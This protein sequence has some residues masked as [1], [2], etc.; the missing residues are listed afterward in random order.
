MVQNDNSGFGPLMVEIL[1]NPRL[2]KV[3]ALSVWDDYAPVRLKQ[4][5]VI[6]RCGH[7]LL[8]KIYTEVFLVVKNLAVKKH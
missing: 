6:K 7:R 4:D 8:K 1:T 2:S 3:S 5:R